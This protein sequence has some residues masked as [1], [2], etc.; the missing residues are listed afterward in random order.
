MKPGSVTV[1]PTDGRWKESAKTGASTTSSS[2]AASCP[3]SRM[4]ERRSSGFSDECAAG[5]CARDAHAAAGSRM[6]RRNLRPPRFAAKRG[7]ILLEIPLLAG[8]SVLTETVEVKDGMARINL[9]A[10]ANEIVW[11]SMLEPTDTITLTHAP[12]NLWTETWQVDISP[13]LHLE[14]SGI[15]VVMQQQESRWF[16]QWHPWPGEELQLQISRPAGVQGQTLTIQKS[17]LVGDARQAGIGLLAGGD[18]AEQPGDAAY[19]RVAGRCAGPRDPDRPAGAADPAGGS[20]RSTD[21]HARNARNQHQVAGQPGLSAV[22]GRR[23]SIL[24]SAMSTHRSR[25]DTRRTGGCC[26]C[27]DLGSG[28]P[29]CSGRSSA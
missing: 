25:S 19:D 11:E 3:G 29:C 7:S 5:I 9:D 21:H 22:Y 20:R 1:R 14:Y 8:E 28:R 16:P 15:P 12:T 26:G 13:I 10:S 17:H 4:W 18:A 6:A 27:G 24:E 2:S 23:T